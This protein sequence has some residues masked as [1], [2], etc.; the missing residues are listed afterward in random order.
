MIKAYLAGIPTLFEGE[1]IEVRY[2]DRLNLLNSKELVMVKHKGKIIKE[3]GTNED[4][5]R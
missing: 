2:P 5:N 4:E 3:K 1:D